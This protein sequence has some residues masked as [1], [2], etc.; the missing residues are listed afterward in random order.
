MKLTGKHYGIIISTLATAYLHLSLFP[1]IGFDPIFLN[2]FG[3]LGLL[4]AYFLPIS[5]FQQRHKLMWWGLA[6]YTL[7][8]IILWVIMGDKNFVAGTSSAIGY[9]AK[10]SEVFLL[11]FLWADKPK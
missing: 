9:Y 11:A 8:T 3:F 7:L 5:F 4:G 2:G 1:K 6:G 10:A